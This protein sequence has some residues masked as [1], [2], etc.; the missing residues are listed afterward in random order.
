MKQPNENWLKYLLV[1]S[2]PT[3]ENIVDLAALYGFPPPLLEYLQELNG[4]LS[5]TRPK[6]FRQDST[7]VRNWLRRQRVM[8]LMNGDK[9]ALKARK[10]LGDKKIRPVLESLIL[11]DTPRDSIPGYCEAIAGKKPSL[12]SVQ[13]YEHYFWNR[14][15]MSFFEWEVYLTCH[16]NGKVL[17]DC[18]ERGPEFALWKLGYREDIPQDQIVKGVLHEATMR[19]FETTGKDNTRDTAMTAK[20]WSETIFR[21]LEEMN[22]TGDGVQRVL[23]DLKHLALRLEGTNIK[24]IDSVTGGNYTTPEVPKAVKDDE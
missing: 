21:S 2:G 5:E 7:K 6:P 20:M 4:K 17:L 1:S 12:K 10:Y 16:P 14:D 11:A 23:D 13:L 19:Y 8:S 3:Y 24:D 9:D 18:H 22:K 15:S